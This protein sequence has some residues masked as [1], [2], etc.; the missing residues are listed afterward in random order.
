MFPVTQPGENICVLQPPASINVYFF[1]RALLSSEQCNPLYSA[2]F[3]DSYLNNAQRKV[4]SITFDWWAVART[5]R[6]TRSISLN[7]RCKRTLNKKIQNKVRFL[8]VVF[9]HVS[10][11][12]CLA[13]AQLIESGGFIVF[14]LTQKSKNTEFI[15]VSDE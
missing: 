15:N 9:W 2:A 14:Y 11:Q 13:V 12:I 7:H 8:S 10:E 4:F 3:D 6:A 1:L 5:I